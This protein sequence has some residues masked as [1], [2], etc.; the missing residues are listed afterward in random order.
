MKLLAIVGSPRKGKATDTLVDKAI[1]GAMSKDNKIDVKKVYLSDQ[2]IEYCRNCLACRDSKTKEPFAKC[3]IRDDMDILIK[4]ILDA[5][6]L[7]FATPLHIAHPTALMMTFLER[8][9][10]IFAKPEKNMILVQGCPAPRRKNKKKA[11]MIIT[12]AIVPPI[13]RCFCDNASQAM[14]D[15][16]KDC[17]GSQI[18]GDLYA[19]AIEKRGVEYYFDKAR[20]IGMKLV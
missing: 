16:L 8:T 20:K 15:V 1:E 14:R 6:A 7:I 4:D 12:N 5:D 10:W 2:H 13:L 18:V 19:G 9:C 11:M 3:S 17:I